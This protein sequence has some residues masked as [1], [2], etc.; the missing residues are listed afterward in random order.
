MIKYFIDVLRESKSERIVHNVH[1]HLSTYGIGDRI[2]AK[3]WQAFARELIQQG[4]L[5]IEGGQYPVLRLTEKSYA[6]LFKDEKVF[7]TP[8]IEY[9]PSK[10]KEEKL[11]VNESL[12]QRLRQLRKRIADERNIPPYII[13]HDKTLK[14]MASRIPTAW[15]ELSTIFGMGEAKL[16]Q[17]G[18]RFLKEIVAFVQDRD[19][20]K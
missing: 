3:R 5:T 8:Y 9:K 16:K 1:Q 15:Q 19:L 14:E 20:V 12:F 6:V 4:Y 17:Y 10:V 11:S 2:A 13:F 7:L 18:P